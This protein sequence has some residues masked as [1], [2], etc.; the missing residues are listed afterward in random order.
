MLRRHRL[1]N[2]AICLALFCLI[3]PTVLHAYT[4]V[5][6]GVSSNI[7]V[8]DGKVYFAQSDDSLTVLNLEAGEV[9]ARKKKR[10]YGGTIMHFDE[11]VLVLGREE[12]VLVDPK[13]FAPLWH[14]ELI[15]EANVLDGR[16]VSYD[17]NGRIECLLLRDGAVQWSYD[18][19]GALQIVAEGDKV[20]AH[21]A[22]TYE[23]IPKTVLLDLKTGDELFVKEPP[24]NKHYQN[25][26]FDGANV[27]LERGSYVDDRSEWDFEGVVIW[28]TSGMEVGFTGA[29]TALRDSRKT[30]SYEPL[31][32]AGKVFSGGR[33]WNEGGNPPST[34]GKMTGGW[35]R[36][37]SPPNEPG[38]WEFDIESGTVCVRSGIRWPY[39]TPADGDVLLS[40]ELKST[41]GNWK[42]ELPYL[43]T[44]RR[45]EIYAAAEAGGKLLLGSNLGHVE[46]IDISSGR[47]LWMYVFPTIRQT[48]SYSS[49]AMPPSMAMAARTFKRE[50]RRTTTITGMR[51]LTTDG[52]GNQVTNEPDPPTKIIY[53]PDPTNPFRMV[54]LY[55]FIAWSCALVPAILGAILL[56]RSSK[57]NV[58]PCTVGV[59]GLTLMLTVAACIFFFGGVSAVSLIAM[60][61]AI[62]FLFGVGMR[63]AIQA[64]DRGNRISGTAI[65]ACL[66][67]A[68]S[69][70]FLFFLPV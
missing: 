22:A 13:T 11:G 2:R 33:V 68:L 26:Y 31:E 39:G 14:T 67:L 19:P 24:A 59:A 7:L 57:Q 43:R 70:W 45:T 25:V 18:L 20:L 8:D 41:L 30:Y 53:D 56:V 3:A 40:V 47:S 51:L 27:Y 23:G 54:P 4:F 28:N 15:Y 35:G 46:C 16:L 65:A 62:L 42:G 32:I 6:R 52:Q 63:G 29:P 17:G 48:A 49:G 50:N 10:V 69:G 38:R 12:I 66:L 37:T 21:C 36:R 9:L 60:H 1:R 58:G 61:L 44:D 5:Q 34:F 55:L 64:R